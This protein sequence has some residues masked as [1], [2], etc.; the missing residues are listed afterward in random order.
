MRPIGD[1]RADVA[2]LTETVTR[3]DN[4][5]DCHEGYGHPEHDV[6]LLT[7]VWRNR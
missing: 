2:T 5:R 4:S 3:L 7:G 6:K 1:A